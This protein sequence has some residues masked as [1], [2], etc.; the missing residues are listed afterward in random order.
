MIAITICELLWIPAVTR[1]GSMKL[2]TW[3]RIG[4][5]LPVKLSLE[6][7]RGDCARSPTKLAAARWHYSLPLRLL[8]GKFDRISFYNYLWC[9]GSHELDCFLLYNDDSQTG[10]NKL[11]SQT[12]LV[13]LTFYFIAFGF[14]WSME[15]IGPMS[16][17]TAASSETAI[18]NS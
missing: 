11:S 7:L 8:A 6:I 13:I 2:R 14:P 18:T 15:M 17:R 12:Y 4:V 5:L 3:C 10:S 1:S 16:V 9:P